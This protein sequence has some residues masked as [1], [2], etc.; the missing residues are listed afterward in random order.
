MALSHDF[1]DQ[2]VHAARGRVADVHARPLAHG[3]QALEHLDVIPCVR[4]GGLGP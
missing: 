2:V 4:P 1:V 3:L